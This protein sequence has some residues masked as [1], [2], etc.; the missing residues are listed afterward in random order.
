MIFSTNKPSN[1][2]NKSEIRYVPPINNEQRLFLQTSMID[3]IKGATHCDSC[4]GS[5]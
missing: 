1:N 2:V 3:R 5:K 4:K